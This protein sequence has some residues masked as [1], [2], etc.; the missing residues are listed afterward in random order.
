MAGS[1]PKAL[2]ALGHDV[3][4]VMPYYGMVRKFPSEPVALDVPVGINGNWLEHADFRLHDADDVPVYFVG[5]KRFF[6]DATTSELIYTP[7]IEQY[8]FFSSALLELPHV[9]GWQPDV[10]HCNDWHTGFVPVLMREKHASRFADTG[11]VFTIHNLAYQGEFGIEILDALGLSRTLFV[12]E[13]LETWG[14]VNFLKSGCAYSDQVNTVSPTYAKEIQ[15]PE[16]GCKLEGLMVHLAEEN[17]LRGILNG[18]DTTVFDPATDPYMPIHFSVETPEKKAVC[19]E[20]LLHRIG[21]DP[22]EGAPVVGAV[23][24]LSSQK[25]LDLLAKAAPELF[26][27]PIQLVIQGLGDPAIIFQL[28]RLQ[29][30]Y[31]NHIRFFEK[32]DEDLAH[33]I[34]AGSDLFAMPS[35]FEPCGLGQ[36]ISM[37]YGTLPVVRSTGG[38]ADTVFEGRNGFVFTEK[39]EGAVVDAFR[40]ASLAYRSPEWPQFV[41]RALR[42]EHTWTQS[43]REYEEMYGEAVELAPELKF[44]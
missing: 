5:H 34:Y 35:N 1:L 8:L 25:G 3:R 22:I 19:R 32:F 26:K 24:R 2:K 28:R 33:L 18:I 44:A 36:M 6:K 13:L 27:L 39:T 23:T 43:A 38:L 12:P 21:M 4:I 15:T 7:G 16:Y 41:E 29:N 14:G 30:S 20:A 40:R 17:R 10:I 42:A 37:R 11:A 31:P 9:L